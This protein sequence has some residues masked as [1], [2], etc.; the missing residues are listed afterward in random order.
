MSTSIAW[1]HELQSWLEPFLNP[2]RHPARRRMCPLYVAG[3]IG[4]GERKGSVANN[5]FH[6][7]SY[8]GCG[9]SSGDRDVQG[10]AF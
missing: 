9:H 6:S 3:L 5:L 2:L 7:F 10:Q 4:P 1:E 8:G